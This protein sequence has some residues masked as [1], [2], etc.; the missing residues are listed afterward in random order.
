MDFLKT[1]IDWD[2]LQK[3]IEEKSGNWY[4]KGYLQGVKNGTHANKAIQ[5]IFDEI[6]LKK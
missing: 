4:S 6:G 1:K 5:K 2:K 3:I